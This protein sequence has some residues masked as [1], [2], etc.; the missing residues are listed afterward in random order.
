MIAKSLGYLMKEED[1]PCKK[2]KDYYKKKEKQRGFLPN[3]NL[4]KGVFAKK[5]M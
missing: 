3:G 1:N 4:L 5:L 2:L